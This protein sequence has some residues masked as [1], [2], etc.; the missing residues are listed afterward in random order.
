MDGPSIPE[1]RPD[2]HARSLERRPDGLI[3]DLHFANDLRG[4]RGEHSLVVMCRVA[5]A[6]GQ[7]A[8]RL[9]TSLS[10]GDADPR[11]YDQN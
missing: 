4:R 9:H 1:M 3:D 8:P 10:N 7:S 5:Q 11:G 6:R 2:A